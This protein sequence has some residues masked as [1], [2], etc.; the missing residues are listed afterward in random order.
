MP[1]LSVHN[2]SMSFVEQNLFNDVTFEI[3]KGDKVGFIGGNGVG[4]TT[5]FKIINGKLSPDSG[6][7]FT[8]SD[9]VVG[10]MEQHACSEGN[11]SHR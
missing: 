8:A 10:Y 11:R 4:K 2:L 9:T 6:Q 1:V 7:V 3:E 5:L